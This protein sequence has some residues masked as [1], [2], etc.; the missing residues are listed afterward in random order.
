M[1]GDLLDEGKWS[2]D[3]EFYDTVARFQKIFAVNSENKLEVVVGNH[4]IGFHYM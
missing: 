3:A 1:S 4:D 2:N